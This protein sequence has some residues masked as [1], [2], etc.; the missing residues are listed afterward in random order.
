MSKQLY[1]YE[2]YNFSENGKLI[3]QRIKLVCLFSRI[4]KQTNYINK[5]ENKSLF[6]SSPMINKNYNLQKDW[7]Q[8]SIF[9]LTHTTITILMMYKKISFCTKQNHK[10]ISTSSRTI[11][12]K[13][14]RNQP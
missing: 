9:P 12:R 5:N 8:A 3:K 7:K 2:N 14:Q 10:V 1:K 11:K 4:K 6:Y 13:G